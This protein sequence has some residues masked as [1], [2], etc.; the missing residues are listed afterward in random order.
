MMRIMRKS[1]FFWEPKAELFKD[2]FTK[3]IVRY[4]SF[5]KKS[6]VII[7]K[8]GCGKSAWMKY[9]FLS[10]R[11]KKWK[12]GTVC[13]WY[14]DSK[15]LID[16]LNDEQKQRELQNNINTA[17]YKK[18]I[19]YLDGVDE[20]GAS[21]VNKLLDYIKNM[22][23]KLACDLVIKI[24]CRPDF[25]KNH[26]DRKLKLIDSVNEL[27]LS[28][29]QLH[30]LGVE[31][32]KHLNKRKYRSIKKPKDELQSFRSLNLK[33]YSLISTPLSLK[34]YLYCKLHGNNQLNLSNDNRYDLYA[35]FVDSI[36]KNYC[37]RKNRPQNAVEI[38]N[39]LD[40]LSEAAFKALKKKDKELILQESA[41]LEPLTKN[42]GSFIT[43]IHET[44]YEFFV[45]KYYLHAL[46][47]DLPT[48]WQMQINV[49]SLSY[50][51]DYADFI[52][53]AIESC[54]DQKRDDIAR[55]LCALYYSTFDSNTKIKFNN[56]FRNHGYQDYNISAANNSINPCALFSLKYEIVFRFGRLSMTSTAKDKIIKFIEFIY[57]N[58]KNTGLANVSTDG[59]SN[60]IISDQNYYVSVLKRCCAI[61][62]SFLGAEKIEIDYV[63]YMLPPHSLFPKYNS[64]HDLA[65]RSHTLLFYGDV[66]NQSI[67]CFQDTDPSQS[68][69]K[70]MRKRLSRLAKL[71]SE[72]DVTQM[73]KKSKKTF[74]FRLFD[75][76]TVYTFLYSR[77]DCEGVIQ[78]Q[79]ADIQT[80]KKCKVDFQKASQERIELMKKIK[81]EII[82]ILPD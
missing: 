10:A 38:N 30:D 34:L 18:T 70:A 25:Y 56:R 15:S 66:T 23:S 44:F 9:D 7:G 75:L 79:S 53:A 57:D 65:N 27:S 11:K 71:D 62:S 33:N 42:N 32:L 26:L 12:R 76:A 50:S 29:T 63:E 13:Q 82:N 8:A 39:Q 28:P 64:N 55:R 81:Q 45:A 41:C 1:I 72:D 46:Q 59:N 40:L 35:C 54:T 68:C 49:L 67:F 22:R 17:R 69:D 74:Y 43:M 58:D 78:L 51:N 36:V 20:I 16:I 6:Y 5:S 2:Y 3:K 61:S 19:L 52:T 14:L 80:L 77:K 21:T 31:I 24:T 37:R 47:N 48:S 4:K 73:D 60:T